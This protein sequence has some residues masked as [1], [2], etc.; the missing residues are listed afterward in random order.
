MAKAKPNLGANVG[1]NLGATAG[2]SSDEEPDA[3]NTPDPP[4]TEATAPRSAGDGDTTDDNPD[5]RSEEDQ[6]RD[7][8]QAKA[9]EQNLSGDDAVPEE[10]PIAPQEPNPANEVSDLTK[11]LQEEGVINTEPMGKEAYDRA[12]S[13]SQ[14][15]K[16][17][18]DE[19]YEALKVADVVRVTKGPHEGRIAAVTRVVSWRD[20]EDLAIKTS[21]RPEA[22]FVQPKELECHARG[23]MRDGEIL[24]LDVDEA[25]LEKV[26]RFMG[27]ARG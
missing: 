9:A 6:F 3:A 20:T 15:S 25:G 19:V 5:Q 18:G 11:H 16:A 1:T 12:D 17:E 2:T 13:D 8:Q 24:I 23:D 14:R 7:D 4:Q 10:R 27:V 26:D 22:N 21:G